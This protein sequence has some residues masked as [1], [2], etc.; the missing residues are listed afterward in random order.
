[1]KQRQQ[2]MADLIHHQLAVLLKK[3]VQDPRLARI[4]LTAV[5]LSSDLKQ[6]K[7]FYTLLK[8]E[9]RKTIQKA[10]NKAIG[11]LRCLLAQAT[12]LRYVPQLQ[13]A[14][15]ESLERAERISSLINRVTKNDQRNE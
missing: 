3:E 13:F 12:T 11:Y 9:E 10:L 1:M 6:A 2:R 14:Y 5:L 4:S 15:D 7:I 8:S